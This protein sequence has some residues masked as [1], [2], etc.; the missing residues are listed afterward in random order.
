VNPMLSACARDAKQCIVRPLAVSGPVVMRTA[1]VDRSG[2]RDGF[3]CAA[4]P[5]DPYSKVVQLPSPSR[6]NRVA[7]QTGV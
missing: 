3:G 2:P 5:A 7:A 6:K 4:E 1:H